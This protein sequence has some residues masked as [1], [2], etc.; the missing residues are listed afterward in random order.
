MRSKSLWV[1]L[2]GFAIV[3]SSCT[4][5][6]P[7]APSDLELRFARNAGGPTVTA[8][9]PSRGEP[10][11]TLDVRVI[12]SGYSAGS[13]VS[14]ALAGVATNKIVTNRTTF[15][16]STEV[17]A[18]ITISQTADL[19]AYD[20]IVILSDGKKGIGTEKFVVSYAVLDLGVQSGLRGTQAADV[21]STGVVVGK[22]GVGSN[23]NPTHAMRWT[24][25]GPTTF[26]AED[27]HALV[28]P[29]LLSWA[30]GVNASGTIVG[31]RQLDSSQTSAR[32]FVLSSSGALTVLHTLCGPT[33][34][35]KQGYTT[36]I[37][38]RGD[39]IGYE[40]VPAIPLY[41]AQGATCGEELPTLA[42]TSYP[43]AISPSG[44][45][46]VGTSV[47]GN[48]KEQPVRWTH[49]ADNSGWDISALPNTSTTTYG[50]PTGVSDDGS[51][52]GYEGWATLV[53]EKGSSFY[54]HSYNS[55]FWP[56]GGGV[57]KL[58]TLGGNQ[59][60]A[61]GL[62]GGRIAGASNKGID[63]PQ[64]ATVREP[65]GRLA[66]LGVL[67]VGGNSWAQAVRGPF[68]AGFAE[69]N[70]PGRG[71]EQH[72]VVWMQTVTL[73]PTSK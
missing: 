24:V 64:H 39:V 22:A 65:D 55:L 52:V 45:Y 28:Q 20:V 35:S 10:G 50:H 1:L 57:Q 33:E 73:F 51:V 34:T 68:V 48:G 23:P 41:W 3:A 38:D 21:N 71:I 44:T 12:G 72:A 43:F 13:N 27:L 17:L 62:S 2:V 18:N 40:A 30:N 59:A 63:Q 25:T 49:R 69:V 56:A 42:G 46:I 32:P 7:S 31:V 8:T 53:R 19:T 4:E 9:D 14:F 61:N 6:I 67:V 15:V 29:A 5:R 47:D 11:Q 70:T 36:D 16:S 66:D 37:N 58:A 60:Y 26:I 54:R